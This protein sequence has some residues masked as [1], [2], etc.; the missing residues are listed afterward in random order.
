MS[1]SPYTLDLREKVI[2]YLENGHSQRSCAEVFSL[3]LSTVHRWWKRYISEGHFNPRKR[4]GSKGKVDPEALMEYVN[5]HPEKTLKQIGAHFG[6]TDVSIFQRL[7]KLGFSYK[8]K[9][10]PMRKQMKKNVKLTKSY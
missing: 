8:K 3:H 2:K 9:R 6:V 4:L 10:S 5:S 1:T 7:Q